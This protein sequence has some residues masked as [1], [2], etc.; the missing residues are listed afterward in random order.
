MTNMFKKS[1]VAL[2]LAG[3]S[4]TAFAADI[5]PTTATVSSEY[6][7]GVTVTSST[8]FITTAGDDFELAFTYEMGANYAENDVITFTIPGTAV[9]GTTFPSTVSNSNAIAGVILTVGEVVLSR[10]SAGVEGGNTKVV[11]RV[12]TIPAGQ[13]TTDGA[14]DGA[15]FTFNSIN[16]KP[17]LVTGDLSVSYEAKTVASLPLDNTSSTTALAT[18]KLIDVVTQFNGAEAD[19]ALDA[20]VDVE[21]SRLQFT[22]VA[23]EVAEFDLL[24]TAAATKSGVVTGVTYTVKGD[25]SFL[26]DED[27]NVEADVATVAAGACGGADAEVSTGAIEITCTD[28]VSPTLTVT[29]DADNEVVIP[30]QT[31]TFDAVVDYTVGVAGA[32]QASKEVTFSSV[33]AGEWTLNGAKVEIPYMPYGDTISQVINL[34]NS[35]TKTGDITVEGF[36]RAGNKFGPVV[37]GT[38]TPSKQVA[39]ADAIKTAL[40]TAKIASNER[41]SLTLVANVPTADVTVYSAY[42]TSGNGARIVVNSSNGKSEK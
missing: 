7:A 35:G 9:D 23:A 1:L 26:L 41:V 40:T 21:K 14:G 5:V 22:P 27:G 3:T 13:A 38:A 39:L 24:T 4:V 8:G 37:V 32:T 16:V 18:G 19:A 2:A 6:L 11:Y 12:S 36:D 34:N 15:M 10:I 42:N 20:V 29:I 25:F 31:F 17:R 28:A 30:D 33:D